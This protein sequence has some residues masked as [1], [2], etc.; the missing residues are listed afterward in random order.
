MFSAQS[1]RRGAL[2]GLVM[3][4]AIAASA[5]NNNSVNIGLRAEVPL[6]CNVSMQ[7]GDG[8][9][10]ANG[11]AVLGTTAE[12]CNNAQGYTLLARA[13]G[14]VDGASLLVDGQAFPLSSN[15]EF[16]VATS[17]SAARTGRLIAFDAGA[18]NGGGRLSLR[19]VAH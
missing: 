19:I 6:L 9:F 2:V 1:V 15:V 11:V 18:S 10:D 16:A 17:P 3:A 5:Y 4:G 7:G 8:V 12:F 13:T 14:D